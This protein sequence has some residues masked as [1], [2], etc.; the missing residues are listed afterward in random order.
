MAYIHSRISF[1][2][3]LKQWSINTQF[4]N[5][6]KGDCDVQEKQELQL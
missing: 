5:S 2:D 6:P 1:Y 3:V 4:V